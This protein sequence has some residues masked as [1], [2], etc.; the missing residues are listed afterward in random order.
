MAENPGAS[1]NSTPE[2]RRSVADYDHI[3]D[4]ATPKRDYS[5]RVSCQS[6]HAVSGEIRDIASVW[7]LSGV[8]EG[9]RAP[10]APMGSC[11]LPRIRENLPI[12]CSVSC[13]PDY[14]GQTE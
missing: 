2:K 14:W 10:C 13:V 9:S 6:Q 11:E 4:L 8:L 12:S 3:A 7:A 1:V 5:V